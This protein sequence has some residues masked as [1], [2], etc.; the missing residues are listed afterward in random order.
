VQ[1]STDYKTN[2]ATV[3]L[4]TYSDSFVLLKTETLTFNTNT[5]YNQHFVF[6]KNQLFIFVK[7]EGKTKIIAVDS[8]LNTKQSVLTIVGGDNLKILPSADALFA[9]NYAQ[10]IYK[11]NLQT[12]ESS[13]YLNVANIPLSDISIVSNGSNVWFVG[14]NSSY[15]AQNSIVFNKIGLNSQSTKQLYESEYPRKCNE[16]LPK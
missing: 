11:I 6:H 12:L 5:L 9:Y 13:L 2:K 10:N 8:N 16:Y 1:Y 7:E 15:K 3:I 14:V 4:Q